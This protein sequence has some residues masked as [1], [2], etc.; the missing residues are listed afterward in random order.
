VSTREKLVELGEVIQDVW[1]DI[2]ISA[3]YPYR[4]TGWGGDHGEAARML[5]IAPSS[6]QHA[7]KKPHN[8]K[9]IWFS[10]HDHTHILNH[11]VHQVPNV[12]VDITDTIEQKI[13]ACK[14]TWA[15]ATDDVEALDG[16]FRKI[17]GLQGMAAGVEYAECFERPWLKKE[18]LYYLTA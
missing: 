11:P 15:T 9:A 4:E 1:P 6:R 13:E 5:D 3:H 12:Y 18:T 16:L 10:M 14:V 8:V 7:G 2:I 17:N